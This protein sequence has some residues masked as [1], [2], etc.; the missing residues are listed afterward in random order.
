MQALSSVTPRY[1]QTADSFFDMLNSALK[2]W[3]PPADQVIEFLAQP[4]VR[5]MFRGRKWCDMPFSTSNPIV[6]IPTRHLRGPYM[7]PQMRKIVKNHIVQLV[8]NHAC[9]GG[10]SSGEICKKILSHHV[11]V[12]ETQIRNIPRQLESLGLIK[13]KESL[14]NRSLWLPA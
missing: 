3:N 4:Q 9:R 11:G 8:K 1:P 6:D 5:I 13:R 10:I 14:R 12:R 2:K 7:S